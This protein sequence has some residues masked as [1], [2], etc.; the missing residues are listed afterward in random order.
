MEDGLRYHRIRPVRYFS[1]LLCQVRWANQFSDALGVKLGHRRVSEINH[2]M[3]QH[4]AKGTESG[5]KLQR[6]I[7]NSRIYFADQHSPPPGG[8]GGSGRLDE[9]LYYSTSS[10]KNSGGQV[11]KR[12]Y[13]RHPK[14]IHTVPSVNVM[15]Y[16]HG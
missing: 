6:E 7:S 5:Q 12:K 16:W 13:Q 2:Q 11:E 8:E 10:G 9:K 1:T 4:R 14:V 3:S 15:R